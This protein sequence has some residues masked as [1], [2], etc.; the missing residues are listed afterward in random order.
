MYRRREI[1]SI[2]PEFEGNQNLL[3]TFLN[4]CGYEYMW[5]NDQKYLLFSH[6]KI[7]LRRAAQ[8]INSRN[9]VFYIQGKFRNLHFGDFRDLTTLIRDLQRI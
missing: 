1:F 6:I 8:L 5:N 4:E 2:V 9:P 3:R 7:K